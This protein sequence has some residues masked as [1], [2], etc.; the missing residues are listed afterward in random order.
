M[1]DHSETLIAVARNAIEVVLKY[2]YSPRDEREKCLR[3]ALAALDTMEE[4]NKEEDKD[5][6]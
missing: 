1:T 3:V 6:S 2:P 5:Q 4:L